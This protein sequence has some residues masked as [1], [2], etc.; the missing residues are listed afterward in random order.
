MSELNGRNVS[1]I[2]VHQP[3]H[4][5][6]GGNFGPV[7]NATELK[8]QNGVSLEMTKVEDGVYLKG[9]NKENHD[10]EGFIPNGNIVSISLTLTVKDRSQAV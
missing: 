6:H 2:R 4:I 9:K 3:T 8:N 7:I 10:W 1:Q 5:E